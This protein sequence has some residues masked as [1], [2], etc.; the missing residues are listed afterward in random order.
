MEPV[1]ERRCGEK[2][3][4][5]HPGATIHLGLWW[6]EA[7]FVRGNGAVSASTRTGEE[8]IK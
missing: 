1:R 7:R 5:G 2:S 3:G 6:L 8:L 4:A